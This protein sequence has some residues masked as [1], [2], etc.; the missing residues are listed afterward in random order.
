MHGAAH[1]ICTL[2]CIAHAVCISMRLADRCKTSSNVCAIVRLLRKTNK[3]VESYCVRFDYTLANTRTHERKRHMTQAPHAHT[4]TSD[5]HETRHTT[6]THM[7]GAVS[8]RLLPSCASCLQIICI[9]SNKVENEPQGKANGHSLQSVHILVVQRTP[10]RR[11]MWNETARRKSENGWF[12]AQGIWVFYIILLLLLV[13]PSQS[14]VYPNNLRQQMCTAHLCLHGFTH[15]YVGRIRHHFD[16][17][18]FHFLDFAIYLANTTAPA[19]LSR[20]HSL[21]RL[22]RVFA[23]RVSCTHSPMQAQTKSN[24][25]HSQ[26][27]ARYTSNASIKLHWRYCSVVSNALCVGHAPLLLSPMHTEMCGYVVLFCA[28]C[29]RRKKKQRISTTR[30]AT[31]NMLSEF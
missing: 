14:K 25:T 4:H 19:P 7:A 15:W 2:V 13:S 12:W 17:I 20:S 16:F 31:S 21:L 5:T 29:D 18:I 30:Y 6:Y 8:S 1:T 22:C 24:F 27:T 26:R 11:L 28:R 10:S 23:I 9:E 3:L